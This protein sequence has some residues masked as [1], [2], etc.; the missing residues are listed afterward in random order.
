MRRA[1][2]PGD[3]EADVARRLAE[4]EEVYDTAP[5]GLCTVDCDLRYVR[6]NERLAAINGHTV[7]EHVGR[8]VRDLLPDLAE[9]VEALFRK[10]IA[11][12]E[13][14][15][16]FEVRG[17]T[18]AIPGDVARTYLT[19]YLPMTQDGRVVGVNIVVQ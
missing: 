17:A 11:T 19:S 13:P 16:N 7:A 15:L 8:K 3:E 12:G 9:A 14:A 1:V 2:Q 6:I 4:L 18:A 10:V 5:V